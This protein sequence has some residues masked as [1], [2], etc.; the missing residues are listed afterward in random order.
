MKSKIQTNSN[1]PAPN[2]VINKLPRKD[3]LILRSTTPLLPFVVM[4][5]TLP[6]ITLI[7]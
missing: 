1:Q 6:R 7:V 2:D 4:Y 3:N 5:I